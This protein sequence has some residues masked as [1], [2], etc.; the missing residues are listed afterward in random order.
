M[1][2]LLSTHVYLCLHIKMFK[3]P[4][5]AKPIHLETKTKTITCAIQSNNTIPKYSRDPFRF[6]E[7]Q[8]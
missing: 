8:W 6:W 5:L 2:V 4:Y 3:K 7:E 1:K